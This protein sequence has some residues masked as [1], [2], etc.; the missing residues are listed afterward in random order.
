MPDGI[1]LTLDLD[2]FEEIDLL[3]IKSIII[4]LIYL[5]DLEFIPY[6]SLKK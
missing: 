3:P 1:Y 2:Y 4:N 5:L 6:H